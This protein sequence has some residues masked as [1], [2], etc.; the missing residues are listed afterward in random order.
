MKLKIILNYIFFFFLISFLFL[1]D[2]NFLILKNLFFENLFSKFN[3]SLRYLILF[4]LVPIFFFIIKNKFYFSIF[5]IFNNQKYIV[6]FSLFVLFQY[7]FVNFL[8][9]QNIQFNEILSLFFFIL[10]ALIYSYFRDFLLNNFHK[11]LFIYLFLFI[12]FSVSS[13]YNI[14]NV[15]ACNNNFYLN[16]L[17]HDK[18]K[19]N[20]SKSFYLEN[21]H[22]SMMMPGVFFSAMLILTKSRNYLFIFLFLLSIII[23][24]LNSSSTFFISYFICQVVTFIIFYKKISN[25]FLIYSSIF[26]LINCFI[27]FFNE[28][29]TKKVTD[30]NLKNVFEKK[31]STEGGSNKLTSI[32]YE[33]SLIISLDTIYERPLG[34]GYDGMHKATDYLFKKSEYEN[35]YYLVKLLNFKDGLGNFFKLV[36]EFGFFSYFIFLFFV[37]YIFNIKKIVPYNLFIIALFI[38]QC[39]RGAGYLNGGFA[40]CLFEIFYIKKMLSKNFSLSNEILLKY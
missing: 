26:F 16:D 7:F 37:K 28:N 30:I 10:L 35:V 5:K 38:T 39:L 27:F 23:T 12:I 34:W 31:L 40:F 13:D 8:Y 33:R 9:L 6:F 25:K 17:F 1:W 22:M 4:L 19:L 18:L 15:G 24:W 3:I 14:S 20:L 2:V 29:C 21:S 11:I 32:I 36:T